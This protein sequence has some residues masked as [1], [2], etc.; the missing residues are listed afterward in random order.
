MQV[1]PVPAAEGRGQSDGNVVGDR[2]RAA[3][4]RAAGVAHGQVVGTG[5]TLREVA[6]VGLRDGQVVAGDNRGWIGCRVV[7][8]IDLAATMAVL[9]TDAGALTATATVSVI[10]G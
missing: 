7:R 8:W 1:Q 3:G 6:R 4:R 10:G 5:L 9:V 2:N